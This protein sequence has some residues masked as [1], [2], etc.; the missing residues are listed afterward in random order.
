[1]AYICTIVHY[2]LWEGGGQDE[3][4]YLIIEDF[5]NR[6]GGEGSNPLMNSSL[7]IPYFFFEVVPELLCV[8]PHVLLN[9]LRQ[10]IV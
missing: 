1:M 2:Y 10:T 9:I 6:G 8:R 4:R 7:N 3:G 5:I